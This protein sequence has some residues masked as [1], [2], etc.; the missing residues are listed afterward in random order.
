MSKESKTTTAKFDEA[1]IQQACERFGYLDA[2]KQYKIRD[3][4]DSL[5]PDRNPELVSRV[6]RKHV[7]DIQE[8]EGTAEPSGQYQFTAEEA[9]VLSLQIEEKL[10]RS[11]GSEQASAKESSLP[12]TGELAEQVID[13][14]EAAPEG[15]K[16][17]VE[18]EAS[19]KTET[20]PAEAEPVFESASPEP[21][22]NESASIDASNEAYAKRQI[23][24]NVVSKS[25]QKSIVVLVERKVKHSL[26]KKY[27]KRSNKLHVHDEHNEST[28]GDVVSIESCRPVS[29]TKCWRLVKVV[30]HVQ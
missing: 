21:A 10:S 22:G 19:P 8:A 11:A 20:A 5:L 6:L 2:E 13:N 3:L 15:E 25:G 29:K 12:D 9:A 23:R 28:V 27:I 26:Y 4:C 16:E 30:S 17:P 14:A 24:G 1:T 7:R 18:A